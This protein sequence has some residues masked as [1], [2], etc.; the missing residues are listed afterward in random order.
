MKEMFTIGKISNTHGVKGELRVIPSTDD[1]TRFERLKSIY[2]VSKDVNEY[3]IETVRYHKNYILL[4]L[5]GIDNMSDAE[6]L[7]NTL[8]K[9]ERKDTLPLGKDEYYIKDLMDIEVMT[10]EGRN[11]GKIV[12]IIVTGSNDVY[13]ID[14]KETSKQM[15]I[16]AIKEVIK[17][18]DIENRQMVVKLL[19]GLEDLWE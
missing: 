11:L 17:K 6:L 10:E 7:K 13:V 19:E 15:L 3:E 12:D 18:V 1:I 4:K 5:K 14:S 16:P 8:I 2:V 9:I